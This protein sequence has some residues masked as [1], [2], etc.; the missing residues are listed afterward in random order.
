MP[1]GRRP[2][3][4]SRQDEDNVFDLRYDAKRKNIP[5][6]GLV[7]RGNLVKEKKLTYA[8]NPHL[9]PALRFDPTGRADRLNV[10]LAKLAAERKLSDDEILELQA[11]AKADPW[12]EWSGKREQPECV[13]D[14]VALQVH[15]RI[16]TQAILKVA[17]REDVPRT[18]FADPEQEYRDAV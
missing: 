16:S 14:P 1:R 6:A 10:L 8:Y 15:E 9:P 17:A 4:E 3:A 13:V 18:L 5:P 11:L 2:A 12:L 7:A